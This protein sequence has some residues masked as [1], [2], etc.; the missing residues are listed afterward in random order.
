MT[1]GLLW[2]VW[3]GLVVVGVGY[4]AKGVAVRFGCAYNGICPG[5][6]DTAD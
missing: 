6:C 5:L 1:V 2:L 4:V 3:L